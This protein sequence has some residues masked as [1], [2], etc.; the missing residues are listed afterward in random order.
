MM[1][2]DKLENA[3]QVDDMDN[4]Y[5][6]DLENRLRCIESYCN[7]Y[8]KDILATVCKRAIR[9]LNVL[10]PSL[11]CGHDDYPSNFKFFD[12]L[13]IELQ[14]YS[15]CDI[16]P[17]LESTVEGTLLNEYEKLT[18]QEKFF[19]ENCNCSYSEI[20]DETEVLEMLREHFNKLYN[21]HWQLK[22]IQ[23][24]EDKKSW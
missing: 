22:K 17:Y 8:A 20:L 24:F 16:N 6:L 11:A 15:Y 3:H 7:T 12:I 19:V 14:T 21:E 1:K 18:P 10:E 13:S 9:K 23:D 2:E 4:K 5:E